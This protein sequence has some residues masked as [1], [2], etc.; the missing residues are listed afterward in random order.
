MTYVKRNER[1]GDVVRFDVF[2]QIID[3][4]PCLFGKR[5]TRRMRISSI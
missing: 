2:D 1:F 3:K 5:V 4:K